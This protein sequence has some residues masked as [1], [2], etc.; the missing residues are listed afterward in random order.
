MAEFLVVDPDDAQAA[1]LRTVLEADGHSVERLVD[2]AG[3]RARA[4]S[5]PSDCVVIERELPDG[6]GL[7]GLRELRASEPWSGVPVV[8]AS[9]RGDDADVW[10]GWTAGASSYVPRPIAP[11]RL[12]DVVVEQVVQRVLG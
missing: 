11:E 1:Q 12:R 8:V 6:D 3:L 7:D 4:G 10:E 2:L 9:V 5:P